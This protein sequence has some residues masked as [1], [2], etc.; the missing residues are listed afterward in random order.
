MG[1]PGTGKTLLAKA[2]AGEAKVPFFSLAGSDFIELYVG[3]GASRV[4]DLFREATKNAPCIIAVLHSGK[5]EGVAGSSDWRALDSC[6]AGFCRVMA[7]WESYWLLSVG[8]KVSMR[9]LFCFISFSGIF[10]S[11]CGIVRSYHCGRS[12]SD[13]GIAYADLVVNCVVHWSK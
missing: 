5:D 8:R 12:L 2:V 13:G 10:N 6:I 7:A 9:G 11:V 3:V 1:P 4:R